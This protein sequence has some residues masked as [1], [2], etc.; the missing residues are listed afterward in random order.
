MI[1]GI[2][3][4]DL[5]SSPTKTMTWSL[6]VICVVIHDKQNFSLLLRSMNKWTVPP[7]RTTQ[8]HTWQQMY[9]TTIWTKQLYQFLLVH[10]CIVPVSWQGQIDAPLQLDPHSI[11]MTIAFAVR[12][13]IKNRVKICRI[14]H[15]KHERAW[16]MKDF[17]P[18][19][20]PIRWKTDQ[21]SSV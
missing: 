12:K 13:S 20:N 14:F 16:K 10:S 18:L 15:C 11:M 7:S 21:A 6:L 3:T 17:T 4:K 9:V 19:L 5:I 1:F 8:A 2:G